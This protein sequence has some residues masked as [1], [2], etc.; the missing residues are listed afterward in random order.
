MFVERWASQRRAALSLRRRHG[1]RQMS[2]TA[3]TESADAL[4]SLSSWS[5][6][7]FRPPT[8]PTDTGGTREEEQSMKGDKHVIEYAGTAC[9]HCGSFSLTMLGQAKPS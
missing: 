3:R 9:R 4:N 2:Q 6:I 1:E 5:N 8:L 7:K